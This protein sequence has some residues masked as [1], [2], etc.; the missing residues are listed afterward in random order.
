MRGRAG[1]FQPS[2]T[3]SLVVLL[4]IALVADLG[5][6][7]GRIV[8]YCYPLYLPSVCSLLDHVLPTSDSLDAR[9]QEA[10]V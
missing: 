4:L 6:N 8:M 9:M 5:L 7:V 3:S 10:K 1:T 2:D